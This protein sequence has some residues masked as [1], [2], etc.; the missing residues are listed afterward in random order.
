MGYS[1][2][3]TLQVLCAVKEHSEKCEKRQKCFE[4]NL[5]VIA[6]IHHCQLKHTAV[7]TH[8]HTPSH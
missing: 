1:L 5:N 6:L 4:R 7:I 8:T 2:L 3:A